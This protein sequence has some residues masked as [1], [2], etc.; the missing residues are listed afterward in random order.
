MATAGYLISRAAERPAILSLD[1]RRSW[2]CASSASAGRSRATSSACPPTIWR[3]AS[4][5]RVRVQ[6]CG[7][8][9]RSRPR[10]SRATAAGTCSREWSRTWTRFQNLYLRGVGPPL[11]ALLVRRGHR[12]RRRP[13]SCPPRGWCSRADCCSAASRCRWSRARW[14]A[15]RRAGRRLHAASSRRSW[16]SCS[17]RHPELVVYGAGEARS[18][19]LRE[20]DRGS[21]RSPAA[22]RSP[23]GW[24]TASVCSSPARPSAGCWRWP[25]TR[26]PPGASTAC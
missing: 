18:P 24:P 15:A 19:A 12:R 9:S 4:L 6:F 26:R 5:A 11:V 22:T 23:A 16:W 14:V 1:R 7:A 21:S 17:T 3:C 8:S 10:G 20:R 25:W 13:R 2:P